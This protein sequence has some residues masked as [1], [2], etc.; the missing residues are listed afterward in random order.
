VDEDVDVAEV[1]QHPLDHADVVV[2]GVDRRLVGLGPAAPA[3]D[4]LDGGPGGVLV[5]PVVHGHVGAVVGQAE[6]D[7]AADA[8]PTTGDQRH[9]SFEP[10]GH[11]AMLPLVPPAST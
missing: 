3:P 2:P 9:P 4:L 6:R 7:G 10:P 5:A 1:G 11:A 8:P